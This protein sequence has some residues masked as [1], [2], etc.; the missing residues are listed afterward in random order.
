MKNVLTRRYCLNK[1]SK[2]PSNVAHFWLYFAIIATNHRDQSSH[3]AQDRADGGDG[4]VPN[5][6]NVAGPS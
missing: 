4:K 1:I 3:V 2:I 5:Q 6:V